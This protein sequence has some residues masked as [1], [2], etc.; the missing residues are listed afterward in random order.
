MSVAPKSKRYIFVENFFSLSVLQFAS[1]VLPLITIPYLTRTLGI[2][3]FGKYVFI[4]ALI[5]FFDILIS[6]GFRLSA[7]DQ[8]AK[9]AENLDFI[10]KLFWTIIGAKIL[11]LLSIIALL[12]VVV[13]MVPVLAENYELIL[14]GLPLLVGNL[15]FPV[16]LFQGLQNMKFITIL[17]LISKVFFVAS[18]FIFVRDLSDVGVAI[19]L[20]SLGFLIAGT[21]SIIIAIKAFSLKYVIP[22]FTEILIQ[23]QN[24]FDVFISNLMVSFYSTINVI[25]LGTVHPGST[26]A[27][28]AL[29]DKVF[30]LVGSLS[31]PFNRAIF[32]MLSTEYSVNK[33]RYF[34][35]MQKATIILF[36]VFSGLGAIVNVLA[37][38]ILVILAGNEG[39]GDDS[40]LTLRILSLAIPFFVLVASSSYHLIIQDKSRSLLKIIMIG[41]GLNLLLVYPVSFFYQSIG[42]A[43]LVLVVLMVLSVLHLKKSFS[44]D[45]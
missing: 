17:H 19:F 29:G 32:P 44:R 8:I 30:R 28:Y 4:I 38:W 14:L 35:N 24:G 13:G 10:S 41:A 37:P 7:T 6:Y 16:W 39:A 33:V 40:V 22:S 27:T 42:L 11:L 9:N 45:R 26:V 15:L 5:N 21:L 36:L 43:T 12:L 31:T 18:I 25:V 1:N 23:L 3:V 20:H 2:E 34:K